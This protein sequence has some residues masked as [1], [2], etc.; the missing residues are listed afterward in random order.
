MHTILGGMIGFDLF[1]FFIS[2]NCWL[3]IADTCWA[4]QLFRPPSNSSDSCSCRK[5]LAGS[6]VV[7][8]QH[9]VNVFFLLFHRAAAGVIF[10]VSAERTRPEMYCAGSE[11]RLT[12]MMKSR[13]SKHPPKKLNASSRYNESTRVFQLGHVFID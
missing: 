6:S 9:S 10:S 8:G 13:P 12:S 5:V 3:C 1:F 11:E 2:T 7:E 4:S